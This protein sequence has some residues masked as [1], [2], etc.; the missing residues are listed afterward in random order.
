M[1]LQVVFALDV[2]DS[3]WVL[4]DVSVLAVHDV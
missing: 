3:D 1:I 4:S 2:H